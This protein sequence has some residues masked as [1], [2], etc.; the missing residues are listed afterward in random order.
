MFVDYVYRIEPN[1]TKRNAYEN[2]CILCIVCSHGHLSRERRHINYLFAGNDF[3]S[4][5]VVKGNRTSPLYALRI[6]MS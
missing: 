4:P 2:G 6:L 1:R 3:I 5:L